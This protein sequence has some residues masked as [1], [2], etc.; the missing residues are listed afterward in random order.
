MIELTTEHPSPI[1]AP[2]IT[3]EFIIL[4]FDPTVTLSPMVVRLI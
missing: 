3:I 4:E 1:V 2:F